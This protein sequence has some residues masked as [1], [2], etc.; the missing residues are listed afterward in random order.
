MTDPM[1]VA[2]VGIGWWGRQLI[3]ALDGSEVV[4]VTDVVEPWLE[5]IERL[6]AGHRF[7]V[8]REIEGILDDH[9]IDGVL[10]ATPHRLHEEQ[11]LAVAK[12]GKHV[13]CEKPLALN[14]SAA[15]RMLE[16]CHSAGVTLGIGH[17]RRFEGA[18]EALASMVGSGDLG[19]L[20]AVDCNWSHNL[21]AGAAPKTWRQDP[22]QAP[23]GTLT[24]LGV[25][26]TDFFQS[27][28]G[29]VG[30]VRVVASH[31]SPE[32]P[33][34]D[35]ITIQFRFT[36]GVAGTLTNLASTPFY[37]RIS[38]FGDAGWAEA[39]EWSNVDVPEPATLTWRSLDNEV[40]SRTYAASNTVRSNVEAWAEAATRGTPYR[41]T[42][43]HL[44][45]N[46][47]I[48]ESIVESA[49]TGQPVRIG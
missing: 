27:I 22:E 5:A 43:D 2:V 23:A 42:D 12:A 18:L 46:I 17:E 14:S 7:N 48:L 1:R 39:R 9:M 38:V 4:L 11:V 19:T 36:S 35:V 49:R 32:F 30:E 47:E 34:D 33:G 29:R 37:S 6:P 13:F 24:A 26:I 3:D 21:F 41:F 31:R 45:H 16:A 8:H 28:A 44:V 25:H 15:R 40:H 10:V 20:L